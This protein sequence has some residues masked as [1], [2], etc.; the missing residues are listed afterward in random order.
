MS[1]VNSKLKIYYVDTEYLEFMQKVDTKVPFS[2]ESDY[3][4]KPFF[5]PFNFPNDSEKYFAPLTSAKPQ[6]KSL[7]YEGDFHLLIYETVSHGHVIPGEIVK[8]KPGKNRRDKLFS[9][10]Q[11]NYMIPVPE[12][13]YTLV[14]D[15]MIN[16]LLRKEFR[17]LMKNRE[18][19][20]AKVNRILDSQLNRKEFDETSCN[21]IKLKLHIPNYL[22]RNK[23]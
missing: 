19:I 9:V 18:K 22:S 2:E 6:H 14:G 16:E 4:R 21:L 7:D 3:S 5:G 11:L 12:G 23:Q 13:A 17:V 1:E 15:F 20:T 10:L 8:P